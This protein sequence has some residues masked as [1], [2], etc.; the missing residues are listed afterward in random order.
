MEFPKNFNS[1]EVISQFLRKHSVKLVK[2]L[3]PADDSGA[4]GEKL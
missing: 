4:T 2:L 3:S 1:F